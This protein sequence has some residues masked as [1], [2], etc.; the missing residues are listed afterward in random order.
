M[1]GVCV[2]VK[3]GSS[4]SSS[5]TVWTKHII[6]RH[7][8]S[9]AVLEHYIAS[10][11][12]S[13]T[14]ASTV[15]GTSTTTLAFPPPS[16]PPR[17]CSSQC[18]WHHRYACLDSHAKG[19]L[20]E[21]THDPVLAACALWEEQHAATSCQHSATGSK[22][23]ELTAPVNAVQ[24]H[25]TCVCVQQC[26]AYCTSVGCVAVG[27]WQA[28]RLRKGWVGGRVGHVMER[29]QNPSSRSL[30][31]LPTKKSTPSSRKAQRC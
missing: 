14:P 15:T 18:D 29:D 23:L 24:H 31:Q 7:K 21:A 17:T 22:T 11:T 13:S 27:V 2:C 30:L 1:C 28:A 9:S 16:S 6:S 10:Q 5:K 12:P 25:V 4:R 19:P 3:A 26:A 20:L 8:E